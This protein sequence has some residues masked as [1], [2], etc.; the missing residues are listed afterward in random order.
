[1]S[2]PTILNYQ[3][4]K[5]SLINF[6]KNNLQKYLLPGDI[7]FDIFSGAGSVASAF[8]SDNIIIANDAE[9]YATIIS[10][11]LLNT[12]NTAILKNTV[13][14]FQDK[15]KKNIQKNQKKFETLISEEK[16][17]LNSNDNNK[18]VNL[19]KNFPTIWNN[20]DKKINAENLKLLGQY[21]L[22]T[23]YYSGTYFGIEQS[24]AIDSIVE[25]INSISEKSATDTLYSCLF[26]AMKEAV[27]AKDGHMAQPLN[28]IKN[29]KRHLK[30][31]KKN[32]A[33]LLKQKLEEFIIYSSTG[34][35]KYNQIHRS[36]NLDITDITKQHLLSD[37]NIKMIY[38]DPPYTDMQYSRYYHLL[39]VA[40]RYDFPKPT[41][42]RGK[43][44]TGLYTEGRNQSDLSKKSTAKKRIEE[45]CEY[46]KQNNIILA[47]S[48]AYPED[49]INQKT[50]RYTISIEELITLAKKIFGSN[51]VSIA[52][53]NYKHANH[54]NSSTKKVF[55]YLIIC[56]PNTSENESPNSLLN[57]KY[58]LKNTIPTSKN[59]IYNTHLYWSQKS[60]NVIEKIIKYLSNEGDTIFDPFMGSGV[61]ILETIKNSMNRNAI[62]CDINDMPN[63][64]VNSIVNEFQKDNIKDIFNNLDKKLN[65]LVSYY[66]TTCEQCGSKEAVIT[67]VVFDKPIRTINK[68]NI[69]A[70]NYTCPNCG[71]NTKQA[72]KHDE[73]KMLELRCKEYITDERLLQ[74]SKIAVGEND[75]LSDLF[76]P[77][78]FSVLNEL[79]GYI[80]ES[81]NPNLLNYLLMSIIHLS[82]ITDLHS[83]SQWPLWIPKK[84]CVEKN[85]IDLLKK[86]ISN[87]NKASIYSKQNYSGSH[88]VTSNTELI[89]NSALLLTKGSQ[90]I[91]ENDIPNDS[92]DLIVTDPPY[93]DQVLYSE[94]MQLYKPIINLNYNLNDEIVVSPS[95]LRRR[96]EIEYFELLNQVFNLCSQKLK[97]GSIMCL[98]FHDSNLPVWVELINILEQ[99]GFKY[100]TQEHIK[101]SKTVKNII[102]PKKSLS[103]DAVLFFENT[104]S[105][106]ET[107][108]SKITPEEIAYTIYLEAKKLLETSGDLSTPELYD[109]GLM[110]ILISNGWLEILSRKYK[111]LVEI[112][113]EYFIWNKTTAKWHLQ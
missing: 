88:I 41:I 113:E 34:K 86:R 39:N 74:N 5:S 95:P 43:F 50:D 16:E 18:L 36:Y 27:F 31:R 52:E 72:D 83:N 28:P 71:K 107:Y 84:N 62:G 63:F 76:T 99:N 101:K 79:V 106:I 40:A 92:V 30:Q 77:R 61:T 80:R 98:F 66:Q 57:L 21:N 19:Y 22:F 64:I 108:N 17:F 109:F 4:N 23:Y 35:N 12:P 42:L 3:G 81:E 38:A 110:E 25:T 24:I 6:L 58:E 100:I 1:M 102:S 47:L 49:I 9:L 37:L 59:P 111:S 91:S 32:I 2:T 14:E 55:E 11:A 69:K 112:F 53:E 54:R 65:D 87:F 103:G 44:T 15:L 75:Y 105:V 48:Y 73:V 90:H 13:I 56:G 8:K 89:L 60:F 51:N 33:Q 96:G 93:K 45:L 97:Q 26:F 20:L 82:K 104:R 85:I 70:V 29:E 68:Y 46:C 10:S 78:N 94:Y 67:K 7:F